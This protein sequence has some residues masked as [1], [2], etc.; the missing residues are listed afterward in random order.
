MLAQVRDSPFYDSGHNCCTPLFK[1]NTNTRTGTSAFCP[2]STL[3]VCEHTFSI[4]DDQTLKFSNV[5]V[6]E[7]N[8]T[9]IVDHQDIQLIISN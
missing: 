8:L 6:F 4:Y 2:L 1:V 3:R 5:T 9:K 7:G